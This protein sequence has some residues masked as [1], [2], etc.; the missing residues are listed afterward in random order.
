MKNEVTVDGIKLSRQQ[1]EQALQELNKP[2]IIDPAPGSVWR[3][4]SDSVEYVIVDRR[5]LRNTLALYDQYH[6]PD[7]TSEVF[8]VP[9]KGNSWAQG[10]LTYDNV[11][12]FNEGKDKRYTKIR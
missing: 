10:S 12:R 8:M 2:E 7:D 5:K 3:N 6:K 1:V 11:S 4:S 9:I